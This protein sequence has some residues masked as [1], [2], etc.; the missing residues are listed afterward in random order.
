MIPAKYGYAIRGVW[1][2][3]ALGNLIEFNEKESKAW[4]IFDL[5]KCKLGILAPDV[6]EAYGYFTVEGLKESDPSEKKTRWIR[7]VYKFRNK[8]KK[9]QEMYKALAKVC[10]YEDSEEVKAETQE[11]GQQETCIQETE[12]HQTQ[13]NGTRRAD[14]TMAGS[15]LVD[16]NQSAAVAI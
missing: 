1:Y 10:N 15:T 13:T 2:I 5:R 11:T 16:S 12:S 9:A 3:S 4:S 7:K 14:D 6:M 8:W